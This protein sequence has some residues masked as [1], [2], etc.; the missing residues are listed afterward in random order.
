MLFKD[1]K[2]LII[3]QIKD[4]IKEYNGI[5]FSIGL[6]IEFF[7]DEGDGARKFV[8]GQN[9]GEQCAVL[10]GSWLSEFYNKQTAYL[11]NVD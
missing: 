9:H 7:H 4:D 8:L 2:S 3:D 1:K 6:S 5:K 10:D 11:K